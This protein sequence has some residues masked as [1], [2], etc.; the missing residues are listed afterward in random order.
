M[1]SLVA[2]TFHPELGLQGFSK[3]FIEYFTCIRNDLLVAIKNYVTVRVALGSSSHIM[4]DSYSRTS[5][6]IFQWKQSKYHW[7][8]VIL[9]GLDIKYVLKL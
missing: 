1:T 9:T 4:F 2:T 3:L 7:M 6:Q 8:V 5:S